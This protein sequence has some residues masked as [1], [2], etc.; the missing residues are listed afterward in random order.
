MIRLQR[1]T[2]NVMYTLGKLIYTVDMSSR[3]VDVKEPANTKMI[4]DHNALVLVPFGTL[5]EIKPTHPGEPAENKG[6]GE[7]EEVQ[8]TKQKFYY[9][10]RPYLN[11]KLVTM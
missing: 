4:D 7:G 2:L 3:A 6:E 9:D 8:G 5:P 1:Y 11:F 10:H